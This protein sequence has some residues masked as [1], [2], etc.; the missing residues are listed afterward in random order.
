MRL[1]GLLLGFV[2]LN[3]AILLLGLS[4]GKEIPLV[5]MIFTAISLFLKASICFSDIGSVSDL[6]ITILFIVCIF[7]TVPAW[8]LVIGAIIIGIKGLETF[9]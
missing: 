1:L 2:D 3:A 9:A 6:V 8:I 7:T 5:L 4:L